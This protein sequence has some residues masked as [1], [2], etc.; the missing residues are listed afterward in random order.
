M[1]PRLLVSLLVCVLLLAGCYRQSEE[2]FQQVDSAEVVDAVTPTN[3][4]EAVEGTGDT[5]PDQ[6][7][8]AEGD[9]PE[10]TR[11]QYITPE[12]LPGQVQQATVVLPTSLIA[13]ATAAPQVITPFTFPS[14]TLSFEEELD[15]NDECVY[16][17]QAGNVLFRLALAWG[18]TFQEIMDL[19]QLDSDSLSIGQLLLIPDCESSVQEESP[20][21]APA[22]AVGEDAP[23]A[24]AI[25]EGEVAPETSTTIAPEIAVEVADTPTPR[26]EFHVVSAGETLESISLRYRVDVNALIE[27]NQLTNPDQLNVGQELQLPQ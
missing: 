9:E 26:P 2:P 13:A 22:I 12:T 23:E 5:A 11:Q 10:A 17:V 16:Q 24:T 21:V 6:S 20:T 19:N 4:A 3:I 7:S 25:T 27:L 1:K 14:P 15:P 8:T 18:T